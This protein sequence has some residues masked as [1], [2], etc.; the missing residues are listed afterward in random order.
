MI[1]VPNVKAI[2]TESRIAETIPIARPVLMKWFRS[3]MPRA[4]SLEIL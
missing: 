4:P 1:R 2:T 3:P